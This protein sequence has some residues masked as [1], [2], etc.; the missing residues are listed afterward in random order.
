MIFIIPL[1]ALA[2]VALFIGA[3]QFEKHGTKRGIISFIVV[4]LAGG[5]FLSILLVAFVVLYYAGGGH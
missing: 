4:L 3:W 1:V 2:I 5:V